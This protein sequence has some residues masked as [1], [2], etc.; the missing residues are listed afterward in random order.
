MQEGPSLVWGV[1]TLPWAELSRRAGGNYSL[2]AVS[3]EHLATKPPVLRASPSTG[4][5]GGF[6][7][8]TNFTKLN[9][10]FL[11]KSKSWNFMEAKV[12]V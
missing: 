12:K 2:Y 9:H 1:R 8:S 7:K 10:N 11:P 3:A 6:P 5:A 4:E